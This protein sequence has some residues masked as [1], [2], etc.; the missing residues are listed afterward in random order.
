MAEFL[1]AAKTVHVSEGARPVVP[2]ASPSIAI[3]II[4]SGAFNSYALDSNR[5]N[6]KTAASIESV[7]KRYPTSDLAFIYAALHQIKQ[8]FDCFVSNSLSIRFFDQNE[9]PT[10]KTIA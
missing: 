6:I 10:V 5:I 2:M 7:I 9:S 8:P 3:Y 1:S 4:K